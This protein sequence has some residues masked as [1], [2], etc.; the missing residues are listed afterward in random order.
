MDKVVYINV[1]S[2]NRFLNWEYLPLRW[3]QLF[4]W[5]WRNGLLFLYDLKI[6]ISDV[7][8]IVFEYNIGGYT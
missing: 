4:N 5:G 6:Y 3:T 7:V 2:G 8:G 1:G